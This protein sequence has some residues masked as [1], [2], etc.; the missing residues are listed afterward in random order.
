MA[1]E[2]TTTQS[3]TTS[4]QDPQLQ[5]QLQQYQ[6]EVATL[7]KEKAALLVAASADASRLADQLARSAVALEEIERVVIGLVGHLLVQHL[8]R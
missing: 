6:T 2:Q 1:D 7:Q 8:L 4:Q 5:R 3:S